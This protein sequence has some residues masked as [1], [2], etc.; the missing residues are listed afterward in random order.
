VAGVGDITGLLNDLNAAAYQQQATTAPVYTTEKDRRRSA[1][2]VTV[3]VVLY[4]LAVIPLFIL[5][6]EYGLIALLCIAAIATG[7]LVFNNMTNPKKAAEQDYTVVEEFRHWQNETS[8]KA[9]SFKAIKSALWSIVTVLYF[10]I[11]FTQTFSGNP[12]IWAYSWVIFLIGGAI[13]SVIR[14]FYDLSE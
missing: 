12:F 14:A 7:I 6:N 4:I 11:S 2:L 9:Q 5:Q 3:A 10:I 8:R 13:E 1:A